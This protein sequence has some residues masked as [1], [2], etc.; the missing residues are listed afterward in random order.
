MAVHISLQHLLAGH[1]SSIMITSPAGVNDG[2]AVQDRERS[3]QWL[4]RHSQQSAH[5][6]QVHSPDLLC[7]AQCSHVLVQLALKFSDGV[8]TGAWTMQCC[9]HAESRPV[10]AV[11]DPTGRCGHFAYAPVW[12]AKVLHGDTASLAL[13]AQS[14]LASMPSAC[15]GLAMQPDDL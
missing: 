5:V 2:L 6:E 11:A 3:M 9:K 13:V 7:Q 8:C 12:L 4:L 1:T 14:M 10:G 15:Q